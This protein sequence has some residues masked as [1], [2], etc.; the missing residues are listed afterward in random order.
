MWP[1]RR[2]A[3]PDD[4]SSVQ[5]A[6][7]RLRRKHVRFGSADTAD[8]S[9]VK[10]IINSKPS[11]RVTRVKITASGAANGVA[12]VQINPSLD[13]QFT[14]VETQLMQLNLPIG[15]VRAA[16]TKSEL[17]SRQLMPDDWS[18]LGDTAAFHFLGWLLTAL[19]ATLGAPFWFDTLNRF[20]SIRSAGK[21]PEE[22]PK[23][24]KDVPTPLEP[25]QSP[26]EADIVNAVR[27]P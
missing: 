13:A 5:R 16:P 19:A 11:T 25:G 15:W 24:P 4:H 9:G 3:G 8:A 17:D 20:I 14:A 2:N 18:T 1:L 26:R 6:W 12:T 7:S 21:A 27:R 23:P 10:F 22:K